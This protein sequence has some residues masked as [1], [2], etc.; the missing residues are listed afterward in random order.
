VGEIVKP[1]TQRTPTTGPQE[2]LPEKQIRQFEPL[3]PPTS[4]KWSKL[5]ANEFFQLD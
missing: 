1:V 3:R 5:T 4:S 2:R